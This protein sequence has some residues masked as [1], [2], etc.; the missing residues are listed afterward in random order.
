MLENFVLSFPILKYNAV[1]LLARCILVA[2][3]SGGLTL[4]SAFQVWRWEWG[5]EK[6]LQIKIIHKSSGL[7]RSWTTPYSHV[8]SSCPITFPPQDL[9]VRSLSLS[10][11]LNSLIILEQTTLILSPTPQVAFSSF[12]ASVLL[13]SSF[14][15]VL[16]KIF[17]RF[18]E[19]FAAEKFINFSLWLLKK[20][21][22]VIREFKR[23]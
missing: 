7:Q 16:T 9:E 1:L 11:R 19:N 15:P 20:T 3:H 18:Q 17:I 6:T 21:I 8:P 5:G 4:G 22:I 13:S 12:P 2:S 10:Q 23:E 14:I